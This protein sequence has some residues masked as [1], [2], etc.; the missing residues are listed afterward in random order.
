MALLRVAKGHVRDRATAED[1]VQE[2]W[3]GFMKGL[4]HFEGRCSIKTWL[5]RILFNKAQSRVAAE[6]RL[7]P[8]STLVQAEL[9]SS[10][11]AVEA[12]RF[13]GPSQE[14]AGHWVHGPPSWKMDPDRILADQEASK[15]VREAMKD[16]PDAQATVMRLRD[17]EGWSSEEV[18]AVLDI[19][20]V[21]QRVLLHRGRS[22]VRAALERR[23][24]DA[25]AGVR[26]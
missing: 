26:P 22:K 4:E 5:F 13:R 7:V 3:V 8:W 2:T 11:D 12:D 14:F 10:Q 16:L 21:N 18:C 20:A 9:E 1:V 6:R 23:F 17:V 24:G 19:S 15:A 25:G